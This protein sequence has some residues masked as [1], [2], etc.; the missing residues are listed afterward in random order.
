MRR[1]RATA[2]PLR[3]DGNGAKVSAGRRIRRRRVLLAALLALPACHS[4][5]DG[6]HAV[7]TPEVE[8]KGAQKYQGTSVP[9]GPSTPGSYRFVGR[10]VTESDGGL[11]FAWSG[12]RLEARFTGSSLDL[13]LDDEGSNTFEIVLDGKVLPHL[14]TEHGNRN[15]RIVEGAKEGQHEIVVEKRTEAMAGEAVFHGFHAGAGGKLLVM[16]EQARRRTLELIGDSITAGMGN[17]GREP[18]SPS[19][20]NQNSYA[21]YGEIVGRALSA[22][23]VNIAWSGVRTAGPPRVMADLYGLALPNK[24]GSKWSFAAPPPDAVVVNL[25]DNDDFTS[26]AARE[27][28]RTEYLR[29]LGSVRR[30]YPNTVIACTTGPMSVGSSQA[31]RQTISAAVTSLADPQMFYLEFAAIEGATEGV[32][33][34]GHPTV[35]THTRMAE[36]LRAALAPRLGW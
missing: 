24:P 10:S 27:E 22:D 19:G 13:E 11:R 2:R 3:G 20:D 35:K 14:G 1:A 30:R 29:F 9:P 17:E 28:F 26:P 32:G 16:P 33:C 21:T 23:V 15:Y 36:T 4:T 5:K 6:A 12:S 34:Y 25:G 7:S 18:C 31:A 8:A